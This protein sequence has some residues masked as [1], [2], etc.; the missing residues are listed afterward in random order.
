MSSPLLKLVTILLLAG[1]ALLGCTEATPNH[2]KTSADCTGGRVCNVVRAVC[3]VPDAAIGAIDGLA[4]ADATADTTTDAAI[5]GPDA[6]EAAGPDTPNPNEVA[7]VADGPLP[8]DGPAPIDAPVPPDAVAAGVETSADVADG[9]GP[10]LNVPDGAGTCGSNADCPDPTKAFCVAGL[11]V[12]CQSGVD[13]GANSCSGATPV[14]DSLSGRC[15][16]CTADSHCASPTRPIC[17]KTNNTCAACTASGQCANLGDPFRAVCASTGACVECTGNPDCPGTT[18]ACD[19]A[20]NKCV[21]CLSNAQCSG[22]APIC[23]AGQTCTG[24]SATNPC[25]GLADPNRVACATSGACVQCTSNA[26]CSGSTPVCDTTSNKCV[27]CVAHAD[28]SGTTPICSASKTCTACTAGSSCTVLGD[29]NRAVCASSGACVQCTGNAQCSGSTP[30]CSTTSNACVQCTTNANCSGASPICDSA[31]KCQACKNNSECLTFADP[32]RAV[33]ATSGPA[34]GACVQC[35]ASS[36]CNTATLPI[37]SS[38]NTCLACKADAECVAKL[39]ATGNPGVCMANIDGHCATDAETVYV[40]NKTGCSTTTSGGTAAV[41]FCAARVGVNLAGT[42]NGKTLV[43]LTGALADFGVAV[44]TKPLTVV[45][46]G[47]VITPAL[48][49]TDGIDITSGEIYLRGITVQGGTVTGMGVNASPTSG[50]SVTLHMDT[51]AVTNNQGGGILLNGAAFDIKNTTVT[52]NGPGAFGGSTA[53]GGILV[54][55]P[56]SGETTILNLVTIENNVGGGLSCNGAITG[57]GVLAT[58]NTEAALGQILASCGG[59]TSCST[60]DGGANCGAQTAP[61]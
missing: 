50:S 23:S 34:G 44:P 18:P 19:T 6:R 22:T 17:D 27:Q 16:G 47:A 14:C 32:N 4:G 51:C 54:N 31:N 24:C 40:E 30:V 3:V 9:P 13:G 53:W 41:P 33:C 43:V 37:C 10:D 1:G 52:G 25:S 21:Q 48:A 26:N 36:D 7:P 38:A 2:C 28:C 45:G 39:G 60:F 61:Q 42:T 57:M 20:T 59:F 55:N 56:P 46:K 5:G 12:G 11:C 49:T 58:G 8:A 35:A 29:P 15:V